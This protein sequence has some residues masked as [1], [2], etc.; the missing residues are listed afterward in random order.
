MATAPRGEREPLSAPSP[1]SASASPTP[2]LSAAF[3]RSYFPLLDGL[4]CLSIIAVVWLHAAG[5]TYTS[6]ILSRGKEGVSL[7]FVISGFLITTILLREQSTTGDISL[8]R[9]YLRSTFRI[10]PLY[11]AILA[12]Y[13]VLVIVFE[14][15]SAVGDQFWR[16]LPYFLTYTSNWFVSLDSD[17]VIFFF[18]WSL[19]T[20]E[21]FYFFWPWVV[22]ASAGPRLPVATMFCLLVLH[23]GAVFAVANGALAPTWLFTRVLISLSPPICFGAIA[24]I[25]MHWPTTF[26]WIERWIGWRWS[27]AAA[28]A[29][30]LATLAFDAMPDWVLYAAMT[31]LVVACALRPDDQPLGQ[32]LTN[33]FVKHVGVV[34]YGIYLIHMLCINLVRALMHTHE[35]SLL[36]VLALAV[37]IAA[38]TVSYRFFESPFLRWKDRLAKRPESLSAAASAS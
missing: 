21:Q 36:F 2:T 37:S 13:V 19:A 38:A 12:L 8:K 14:K 1:P 9:F 4:R 30:T 24:A 15:Q 18:A 23:Y 31:W 5:G 20:E 10:F 29:A 32:M 11:Y 26:R 35:G 16:N 25:L 33:P 34:S 27:A 22:K 3:S 28:L 7:F 6:G 17:R